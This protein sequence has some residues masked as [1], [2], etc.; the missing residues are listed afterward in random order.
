MDGNELRNDPLEAPMARALALAQGAVGLTEPNPRVGCV[1][2]SAD[3]SRW[4]GQGHTQAAGQAHAEVMALRDAAARG[5]SVRGATAWVTLE[6]CS[7]HGRTPPCCDALIDAGMARVVVAAGDP[8]PRV[9]GQGV[10]RLRAA[11]IVVDFADPAAEQA[12]RALNIGFFQRMQTGRPWVRMKMAASLDG[13]SAL[14]NGVSQWITGPAARQDGHAWRRRAGAVLTGVGTVLADD[15]QLN[16][17]AVAT[18]LQP[19]RVV[20]DARLDTP[21]SAKLL[22]ADGANRLFYAAQPSAARRAALEAQGAQVVCLPGPNGRVD[23]QAVVQDLGQRGI[24]ELH[25]EA[26]PR[27]NASFIAAGL[28]D[29]CLIYLAPMLIGAGRGMAAL[30]PLQDLAQ[31][32]RFQ[33]EETVPVGADLRLRLFRTPATKD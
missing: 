1:I 11:G 29:E 4:L 8:N 23:L 25:V 28:V 27:L 12:S 21:T 6:P 3:G 17:R 31:A 32:W 18:A 2:T 26:G 10:A 19:M 30:G 16:V 13:R 22:A 14:D 5:Q 9:N 24:N 7:H 20:I 15:P 33:F